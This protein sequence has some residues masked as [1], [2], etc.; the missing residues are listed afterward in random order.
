[1]PD[2]GSP[3]EARECLHPRQS[4]QRSRTH[5]RLDRA[6][7]TKCCHWCDQ[8]NIREPRTPGAFSLHGPSI[9]ALSRGLM[10]GLSLAFHSSS[11]LRDRRAHRRAT[12]H[13]NLPFATGARSGSRLTSRP[14]VGSTGERRRSHSLG[15]LSMNTV[16]NL[17]SKK[18]LKTV[19][20]IPYSFQYVARLEAAGNFPRESDL[21][22]VGSRG[23]WTRFWCGSRSGS[24]NVT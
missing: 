15:S 20:G 10:S 19:L 4:L 24:L 18:E 21:A 1:M 11:S 6:G 17:V 8:A 12:R 14:L 23:S 7:P 5:S 2:L 13:R 3:N 16:R 22:S 9:P